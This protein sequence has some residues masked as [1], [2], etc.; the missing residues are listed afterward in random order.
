MVFCTKFSIKE[1]QIFDDK[2]G[3]YGRNKK[4]QQFFFMVEIKYLVILLYF[5]P[6]LGKKQ[7]ALFGLLN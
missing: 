1:E 5:Y 2:V 3:Y 6:T 7:V 4:L